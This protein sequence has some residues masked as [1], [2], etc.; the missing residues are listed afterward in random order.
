VDESHNNTW[1]T[2]QNGE[3][4]A[5][6]PISTEHPELVTLRW[7]RAVTLSGVGLIWTGFSAVEIEAFT[8]PDE[9]NVGE[10]TSSRWRRV[11]SRGDIDALYPLALGPHWIAFE[12]PITTRS[13]PLRITN[14][15]KSGH[16]HLA[17]KVKQG[18]RVW[19]GEVMA[20]APLAKASTLASL[21]LP[22]TSDEPPPIPIKFILAEAGVVTLVIE[23]A[24]NRR[25]RNLIS[26]T[27]FPA[28]ERRLPM[29]RRES[30]RAIR[31]SL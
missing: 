31:E 22:K 27:P 17:D 10:A 20:V 5:T 18:R 16:P 4:G 3:N 28:G 8:G 29:T 7:P 6:L 25:V 19:L 23:D 9:E 21:V 11:A 14:G 26:Q 24:Q 15:A 13:V 12:Q 2:W 1:K 30:C